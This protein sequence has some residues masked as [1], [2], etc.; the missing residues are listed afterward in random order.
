VKS[1]SYLV[2]LGYL[3]MTE[4]SLE[5]GIKWWPKLNWKWNS[6]KKNETL[7]VNN[8]TKNPHM[9]CVEVGNGFILT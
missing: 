8:G 6:P 2:K 1:G 4:E 7:L 3:T 5:G 9:G